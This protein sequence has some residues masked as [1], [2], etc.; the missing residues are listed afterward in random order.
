M[1]IEQIAAPKPG[2]AQV[3]D[4]DEISRISHAQSAEATPATPQRAQI[5]YYRSVVD[6]VP[7]Y[8]PVE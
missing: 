5:A 3:H 2:H 4:E 7:S 8:N 1:A 6:Q